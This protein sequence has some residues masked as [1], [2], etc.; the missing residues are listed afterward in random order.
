MPKIEI[1]EEEV[2]VRL[3]LWES[4][5][6]FQKTL[7]IPLK[8][9]RGA[10]DDDGYSGWNLGIRSPGTGIPGLIS[11][12]SYLKSG[13]WQYVFVTRGTHRV[14]IELSHHKYKRLILGVS[15]ARELVTKINTA[16]R[17]A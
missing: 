6:S 5:L 1:T 10:T 14:V 11:A 17:K 13:D 7:H 9:I 12:G 16:I 4:I 8:D 3:N 15:N 2:I